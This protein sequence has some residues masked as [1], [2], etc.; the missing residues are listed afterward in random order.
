MHTWQ[1][2]RGQAQIIGWNRYMS[3]DSMVLVRTGIGVHD[4]SNCVETTKECAATTCDSYDDFTTK[5]LAIIKKKETTT[6]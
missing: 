3:S 1:W 2:T 6:K 5:L 4:R